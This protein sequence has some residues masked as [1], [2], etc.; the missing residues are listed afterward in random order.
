MAD[1][2]RRASAGKRGLAGLRRCRR[3]RRPRDDRPHPRPRQTADP[4][5]A[6]TCTSAHPQKLRD[7][8]GGPS[9]RQS[10]AAATCC[11]WRAGSHEPTRAAGGG[12]VGMRTHALAAAAQ[13]SMCLHLYSADGSRR[14]AEPARIR[15]R[16]RQPADGGARRQRASTTAISPAP[17]SSRARW[18]CCGRS[19]TRQGM[20]VKQL[21]ARIAM[22]ETTLIRN[23][24]ILEREGW[25]AL[26]VGSRRPASAHP[27]ADARRPIGVR[28][29]LARLEEGA[30][31]NRPPAR[32]QGA[33]DQPQAGSP[34]PRD[35]ERLSDQALLAS[36]AGA[37]LRRA[38]SGGQEMAVADAPCRP[39]RRN[40]RVR[41]LSEFPDTTPRKGPTDATG[42]SPYLGFAASRHHERISRWSRSA[43][44]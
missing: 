25:V 3:P 29:G 15:L 20:T 5:A 34:D 16:V 43:R 4:D 23:L 32:R 26:E 19:R 17:A 35:L 7:V 37:A 31:G 8:G 10:T 40:Q 22:H 12:V 38:G 33:R 27:V 24:R 18:R 39:T 6:L 14:P 30:G 1:L 44:P 42:T 36:G 9:S 41:A 11:A 28:Q 21:A 2:Q 13:R